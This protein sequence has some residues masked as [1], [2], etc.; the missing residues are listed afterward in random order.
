MVF[1]ICASS[2]ESARNAQ[3]AGANRI[4]LCSELGVGGVTPSYGL[5]KKVMDE[6]SI[7]NCVL[8]RP[9]S[10]NFTYTDEEF[11]V[12]FRDIS[13]CR[14]LGCKGVVTGVLNTDNTID[15]ERTQQL[16]EAAGDIDFIY[17]RA[18]DCV[19]NPEEALNLLK[20]L[21]VKRILTSGGKKSAVEGLDVLKK[22][23]QQ[24]EGKITIMPGGGINPQTILKIKEAGFN[25]V[26]FSG[27]VF[28]KSAN[29]M[30]FSFNTASFLDESVRPI[31][32]I[33]QIK[34]IMNAL[35]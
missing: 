35:K 8:I 15:K 14:E 21:G 26:H 13:F 32:G 17:H 34:T 30:P 22:L 28:E 24:A 19:P 27:T 9:R 6:L 10:G 11:D 31:S 33:E 29:E 23:N 18:F 5:I 4:E 2:F 1:E 25:E 12:M 20:T 7:E 3:L 16:I